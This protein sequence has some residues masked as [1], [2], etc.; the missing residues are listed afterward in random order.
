MGL[1]VEFPA[2]QSKFHLAKYTA[3]DE[4]KLDKKATD[5]NPSNAK[6]VCFRTF[7]IPTSLAEINCYNSFFKQK[8]ENHGFKCKQQQ[9]QERYYMRLCTK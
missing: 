1:T 7:L 4:K 5:Y 9:R 2:T 3:G 8:A 6:S